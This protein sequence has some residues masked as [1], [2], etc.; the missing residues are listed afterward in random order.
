L[1]RF[2]RSQFIGGDD[3]HELA[4]ANHVGSGLAGVERYQFRAVTVRPQDASVK[5]AWTLEVGRVAMLSGDDL[6]G[7]HFR[8]RLSRDLPLGSRRQAGVAG[9]GFGDLLAMGQV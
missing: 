5:H 7:I 3:A 8:Q 1:Y 2:F 6:A 4:V 9:N